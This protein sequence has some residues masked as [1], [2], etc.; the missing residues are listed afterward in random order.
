[1]TRLGVVEQRALRA[2]PSLINRGLCPRVDPLLVLLAG[3][4]GVLILRSVG[5]RSAEERL[6][7]MLRDSIHA[8]PSTSLGARSRLSTPGAM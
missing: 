8:W 4:E 1:M 3:L 5:A 7:V 6:I 2:S